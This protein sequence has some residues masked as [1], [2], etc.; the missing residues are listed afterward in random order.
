[1]LRSLQLVSQRQEV[2]V[3]KHTKNSEGKKSLKLWKYLVAA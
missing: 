2:V 3:K 1:M